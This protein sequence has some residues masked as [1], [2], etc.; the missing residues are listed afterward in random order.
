MDYFSPLFFSLSAR[1]IASCLI[2]WFS[3]RKSVIYAE[4]LAS[5]LSLSSFGVGALLFALSSALPEI[6][7]CANALLSGAHE[8]STGNLIGSS[9]MNATMALGIPML[10]GTI[11]LPP[12]IKQKALKLAIMGIV[13]SCINLMNFPGK[14]AILIALFISFG[15][16]GKIFSTQTIHEQP[17][18]KGEFLPILIGKIIFYLALVFLAGHLAIPVVLEYAHQTGISLEKAGATLM[19]FDTTLPEMVLN[20]QAVRHGS[21]ALALGNSLCSIILQ[22]GLLAGLLS[23]TQTTPVSSELIQLLTGTLLGLLILSASLH[24]THKVIQK[25]L[26]TSGLI[27]FAV[28]LFYL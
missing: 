23:L 11:S 13:L 10:I 9:F 6:S 8:L 3:A 18:E 20:V 26:T 4:Q 19:L 15:V 21:L 22:N 7:I 5:Y 12:G 14:G 16:W 1:F 25:I 17:K 27:L 2:L 24:T 28:T